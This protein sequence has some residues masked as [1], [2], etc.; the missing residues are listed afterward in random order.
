MIKDVGGQVMARTDEE[1]MNFLKRH[2]EKYGISDLV[3][4]KEFFERVIA[5]RD[6]VVK[7]I[8]GMVNEIGRQKNVDVY[9]I[10][11]NTKR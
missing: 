10:Y 1:M 5:Y 11:R 4:R 2:P 8:L 9:R 3:E 6:Q 7:P